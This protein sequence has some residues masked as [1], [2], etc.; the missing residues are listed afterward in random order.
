MH[1]YLKKRKFDFLK[2]FHAF[3]G[4]SLNL[5]EKLIFDDF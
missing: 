5:I 1:T 3:D 4:I 2:F